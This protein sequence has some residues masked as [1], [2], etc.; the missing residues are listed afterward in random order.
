[1]NDKQKKE[2][3]EGIMSDLAEVIKNRIDEFNDNPDIASEDELF[4]NCDS[5][6]ERE[7][8][9]FVES[10]AKKYKLV[11]NEGDSVCCSREK[12][13]QLK[14]VRELV[15]QRMPV[16]NIKWVGAPENQY[17]FTFY[18]WKSLNKL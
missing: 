4:E 15:G 10:L 6:V 17:Y 16:R 8:E 3:F 12:L 13:A 1:M 9:K 11:Y 5:S 18:S 7:N 2:L 14:N